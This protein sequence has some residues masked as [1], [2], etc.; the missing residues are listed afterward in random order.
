VLNHA[1]YYPLSRFAMQGVLAA[2][3]AEFVELQTVRVVPPVLLAGVITLFALGA[4]QID[5]LAHIL[6]GHGV[7]SFSA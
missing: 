2:A 7:L 1:P 3:I 6:F 4:C 5:D